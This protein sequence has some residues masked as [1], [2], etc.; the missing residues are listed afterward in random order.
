MVTVCHGYLVA[1]E[2]YKP[3]YRTGDL[4]SSRDGSGEQWLQSRRTTKQLGG[5]SE[6]SPDPGKSLA[7]DQRAS[8]LV[9]CSG[10]PSGFNLKFTDNFVRPEMHRFWCQ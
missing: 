4:R 5:G 7:H 8:Q 2:G 6:T 1:L 10:Q 9:F 3:R